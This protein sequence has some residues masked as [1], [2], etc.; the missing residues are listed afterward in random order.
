MPIKNRKAAHFVIAFAWAIYALSWFLPVAKSGVDV[1]SGW[2]AFHFALTPVLP[3]S[4]A[5]K[6]VLT[7]PWYY[8]V[9]SVASA[10]T[11]FMF[12][13]GPPLAVWSGSRLVL[14]ACAWA[15]TTAFIVNT[16]W[17]F[18]WDIRSDLSV[19]YFLW[20]LSFGVLAI[21]L[22][23]RS[24]RSTVSQ[25]GHATQTEEQEPT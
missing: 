17:Y 11:T 2:D 12:V 10:A 1:F 18:L 25:Y 16:H 19:G 14:R 5:H 20:W 15:A 6:D 24:S 13:V 22:F 23:R 7:D 9:L 8:Q 21:G 4:P 3:N